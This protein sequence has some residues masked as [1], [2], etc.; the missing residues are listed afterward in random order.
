VRRRFPAHQLRHATPSGGARR[1]G[2]QRHL[3]PT[4]PRQPRHHFGLPPRHRQQRDDRHRPRSARTRPAR[5]RR[6]ALTDTK[7]TRAPGR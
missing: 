3:T 1:R 5:Q 2:A 7:Q 6:P 4:R